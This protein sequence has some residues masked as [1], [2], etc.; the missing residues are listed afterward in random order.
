MTGRRHGGLLLLAGLAV[1]FT[2][3][4]TYVVVLAL[5]DIMHGVGLSAQDL[6]KGA[7]I[8]SGSSSGTSRCSR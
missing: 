2:A 5:P 8:I 6:Q 7:P 1:C 4:D 3:A